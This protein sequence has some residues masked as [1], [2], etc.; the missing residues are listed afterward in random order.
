[1]SVSRSSVMRES[2]AHRDEA[3]RNRSERLTHQSEALESVSRSSVMRESN[4]HRDE[5]KRNRSE[6][7]ARQSEALE[8]GSGEIFVLLRGITC[9]R[10]KM[11]SHT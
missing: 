3:K 11:L 5:A 8:S 2:N 4:A 1:M 6:R 9:R 7:L 10:T